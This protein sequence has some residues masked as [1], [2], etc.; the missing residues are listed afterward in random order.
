[1]KIRFFTREVKV[2]IMTVI[3]IF[4]LYF[5][6]NFL[7][8]VDIFKPISYYYAI[9]DDIGG[10]VPSSPVYIKG[11]KTGQVEEISYDF[12]KQNAFVV[13]I[14][15][16]KKIKLPKG[17]HIQLFDDGLM[18]GKAI[19]IVFDPLTA[20]QLMH[21]SGDTLPAD[22]SV[23]LLANVAGSLMPKIENVARQA[24]SLL[25][26]VR[27]LIESNSLTNSFASIETTTN[28]LA[29]SSTKLKLLLNNDFPRIL[30]D[31]NTLTSDF[32]II[33]GN[34]KK[35]D[36]AAT[37]DKVDYTIKNLNLITDKINSS[38]GSI[39]LLLNDKSLYQNLTNTAQSADNLIVDL[40][41][42]PK[43]YINFSVFGTKSK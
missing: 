12:S 25:F 43:R 1:M 6:L 27:K 17:A 7:K 8:G 5:G 31:V 37:F 42:N 28:E 18:G 9:Y 4:L 34:L 30:T 40:K 16:E 2:G 22:K 32:K 35:I 21:V 38:N 14:S 3:A 41:N 24:D 11:Y 29:I 36:F 23:G 13:K 19:Q 15:V 10:L 26:S 39:G 33:S 20:N